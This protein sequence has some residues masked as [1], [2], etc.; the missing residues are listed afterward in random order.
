M[1]TIKIKNLRSLCKDP[2]AHATNVS[3]ATFTNQV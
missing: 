3:R 2:D 1:I